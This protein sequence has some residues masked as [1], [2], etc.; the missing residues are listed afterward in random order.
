MYTKRGSDFIVRVVS[1]IGICGPLPAGAGACACGTAIVMMQYMH[2][3][4]SYVISQ[5]DLQG[6][7]PAVPQVK[8]LEAEVG[9]N[10]ICLACDIEGVPR[11]RP[12]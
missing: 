6:A 10:G 7:V 8:A 4:P 9:R 2:K 3:S 11:S 12:P 1:L 5:P